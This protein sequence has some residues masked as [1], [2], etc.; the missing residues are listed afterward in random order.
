MDDG[1]WTTMVAKKIPCIGCG[2]RVAEG[3]GSAHPYIGASP[4]C[5][6]L[7]GEV[8][9][10]E[11]TDPRYGTAH[12]L[13]VDAYAAQHPGTPSPQSIQ[14]VTIHLVGLYI[15]FELGRTSLQ[16]RR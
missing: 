12:Q 13:T 16:A 9:A 7:Y 6:A 14:S 3:S 4:G 10:R 1:R 5:W 15:V 8:L 2:A 11:Y